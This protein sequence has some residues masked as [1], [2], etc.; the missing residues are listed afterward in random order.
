MRPADVRFFLGC[1]LAVVVPA[2]ALH[3]TAAPERLR[4][5]LTAAPFGWPRVLVAHLIAALPLGV[6]GARLLRSAPAV[7][8]VVRGVWVALGGAVAGAAV[9]VC[10]GIGESVAGGEFGAVP[11]LLLR[12]LI[13]LGL[14]LP[15]C[16]WATDPPA[17]REPA[18]SKWV[19]G[20]GAAFALVPCGLYCD[21][22]VAARTDQAADLVRRAR[23]ARAEAVLTGLVELGSDRAVDRRSLAAMRK[24]YAELLPK[25]EA[26]AARPLLTSAS[27]RSRAERA[28]VLIQLDRPTEAAELL[29]PLATPDNDTVTLL[30]ASVYR[31]LERWGVSDE[32]YTRVLEKKLPNA[33]TDSRAADECAGAIE[34]LAFNA[35]ADRRPG[36]AERALKRGLESVP[37]RAALFHLQLGKHYHDGGRPGP[38]LEHL[39]AAAQ[40]DPL[41]APE[42]ER[43]VRQIHTATPGCFSWR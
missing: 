16:V 24:E 37:G 14:V 5:G 23:V 35:R 1:V 30:L 38:A 31:D 40:L 20:L 32:L 11:L 27:N 22:A 39:R 4:A 10:P 41:V 6:L 26:T 25:L 9:L 33:A 8:G 19:F 12:A 28:L 2:A 43:V 13:A 29:E 15:W 18:R 34:G 36:D 42:A 7:N 17:P 3:L 21:A